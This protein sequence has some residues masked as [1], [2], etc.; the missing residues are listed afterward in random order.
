MPHW[1][2]GDDPGGE[3]FLSA[4]QKKYGDLP[5]PNF[6][7]GTI[8]TA[9]HKASTVRKPLLIYLYESNAAMLRHFLLNTICN[10]DAVDL[11]VIEAA[12]K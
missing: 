6:E 12:Q 2:R 5:R 7:L 3:E 9:V 4:F 8:E 11:L 10:R 1:I